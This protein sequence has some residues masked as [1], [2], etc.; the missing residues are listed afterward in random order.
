MN[1]YA[2][3][4]QIQKTLAVMSPYEYVYLQYEQN[5]EQTTYGAFRDLDIYKSMRGTV[6]QNEVFG[7]NAWQQNYNISVNGGSEQIKY[8]LS[9]N[10][11]DEESILQGSAF[12]R[13]NVNFKLNSD[14]SKFVS[15]DFSSR[16]SYTIIDGAGVNTGTGSSS[17]LRDA[18]KYAPV[19]PMA[20]IDAQEDYDDQ[21]ELLSTLTNPLLKIADEYKQQRRFSNN[22]NGAINIKFLKSLVFR[23]EIGYQFNIDNTDFAWGPDAPA[24][25]NY[26]SQPIV[27]LVRSEGGS[28][29]IANTLT[30][31]KKNIISG[32]NLNLL[33]GQEATSSFGK[34]VTSE[35]RF[36]PAGMSNAEALAMMNLGTPIPTVTT[37]RADDRIL[38]Y[39]GRANYNVY[40]K[41]LA[42]VTFR[43]DGSSLF[44]EGNRWGYFPSV[45]LAWRL[46]QEEFMASTQSWLSN[47]KFRLSYGTAGN[48][49]IPS[50]STS[51][52]YTTNNDNKPY[53]E[54][55]LE[56]RQ[57][58]PDANT[59]PNPN[60]K[61]ETTITRNAGIDFGFFDSKLTGSLDLYNNKTVDLLVA[62]P[63]PANTG[64]RQQYQN[65]GQT[66]NKG[67]ELVLDGIIV[68]RRDFKLSASFNISFNKNNVDIFRNGDQNWKTYNS[69]WI[70]TGNPDDY[71]IQEGK[72]VGQ[73]YGYT[74][75]GMYTFDDFTFV[76]SS[77]STGGKWQIKQ[78]VADNSSLLAATER[79]FG[80]GTLKFKDISG[81]DGVPDGDHRQIRTIDNREYHTPKHTGWFSIFHHPLK[82]SIWAYSSTRSMATTF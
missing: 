48:N 46:S 40:D 49:R 55:E 63:L 79:N 15:F 19:K 8:N 17:K 1:A 18:V 53:Y 75:E 23:S 13:T 12:E 24:T 81:P 4:R 16:L 10:H 52:L 32:H 9:L 37:I 45:A 67:V 29:R 25:S 5:Q 11:A 42:T 76:P 66:S 39:F 50:G 44:S 80:P 21:T 34:S 38:S 74:T 51:L 58:R 47:L 43:S 69:G 59:L 31:D 77:I 22:T 3:I 73:I 27:R 7:G 28:W 70:G 6:W 82:T 65:V 71:I 33:I 64:Y 54:S 62:A 61:W 2:G 78:G 20:A 41:Y 68:E 60:L 72:P 56:S 30:F 57:L 14:V 26:G 35:S 36:F